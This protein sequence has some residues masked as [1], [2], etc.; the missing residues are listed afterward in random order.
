MKRID[1]RV[2]IL[3][4]F[5]VGLDIPAVAEF[6]QPAPRVRF[7]S[8]LENEAP[9]T[10]LTVTGAPTQDTVYPIARP[11]ATTPARETRPETISWVGRGQPREE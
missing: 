9:A 8:L 4:V 1:D 5:A 6:C 10:A 7:V 11:R 3:D 2:M